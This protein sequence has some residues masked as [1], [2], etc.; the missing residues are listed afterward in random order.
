MLRHIPK[1]L[2]PDCIS[3]RLP[4]YFMKKILFLFLILTLL[5]HNS[6]VY[7]NCDDCPQ[8]K[9]NN[10]KASSNTHKAY[11]TPRAGEAY[12]G[13]IFGHTIEVPAGDRRSESAWEIGAVLTKPAAQ[14]SAVLPIGGIY[15]WQH[16]DNSKLFRAQLSVLE[17][18]VFLSRSPAFL[19]PFEWVATFENY[20]VPVPQA[21][22]IDGTALKSQELIWGYARPGFGIGYRKQV[23]PYKQD[24]MF[25]LDLTAEPGFEFFNAGSNTAENFVVP[26]N[27]FEMRGHLQARLDKLE[28]NI[29]ELP[30][31]GLA[32][33]A[34]IIYGRRLNWRNW[35]INGSE[36]GG[37]DYYL[38]TGYALKAGGIPGLH[39]YR[40][41]LIGS[42][43]GGAG[44]GLDR[45]SAPMIG[46]G[47]NPLGEEYGSTW[48]PILPGAVI[49]E[50]SP[51]HYIIATGEY[52]WAPVF[53]TYLGLD[54]SV[55]WLDR[56]RM[57]SGDIVYKNDFFTSIGANL[58]TGF[59]FRTL[60]QVAYNYN[61]SEI[62]KGNYGGSE[63]VFSVAHYMF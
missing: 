1:R 18:E 45:F 2:S 17:N 33:G 47:L 34:D 30:H 49:Q 15:L 50:F 10:G 27:T 58:T 29:L 48:R 54:A 42:L 21:V 26:P 56:P 31:Q 32:A 62:R 9:E 63:I 22:M 55:A 57:V 53:F 19:A 41:R 39:D 7:A 60:L 12:R 25:A 5:C 13:K 23:A 38:F 43:H 52:R 24:N 44:I 61:F 16:P 37:H 6:P 20:T 46:G 28:R 3:G 4:C 51:K 59:L 36:P 14:G 11:H 35:G 40:Q 8:K